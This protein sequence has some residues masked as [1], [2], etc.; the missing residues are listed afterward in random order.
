MPHQK[1]FKHESQD[2]R[3]KDQHR[4]THPSEPAIDHMTQKEDKKKVKNTR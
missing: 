2:A 1:R 4:D 3:R